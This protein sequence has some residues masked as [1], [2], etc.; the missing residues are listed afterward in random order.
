[1]TTRALRAKGSTDGAT[2]FAPRLMLLQVF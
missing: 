2:D 1:M